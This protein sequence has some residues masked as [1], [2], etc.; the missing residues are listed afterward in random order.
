MKLQ[1]LLSALIIGLF[2][3]NPLSADETGNIFSAPELL[4]VEDAPLNDDGGIMYPSPAVFDIDN[5]GDE[6]LVIGS[7][8]GGVWTCENKSSGSGDPVWGQPVPVTTT[9]GSPL[10]LNNW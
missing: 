7:I 4:M 3:S 9:D 2:A 10:R 5:D 6:E 8:F 1:F